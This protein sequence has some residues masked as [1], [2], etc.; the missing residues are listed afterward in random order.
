[1]TSLIQ[2]IKPP[3]ILA[4]SSEIRA[5][6]LRQ[7]GIEFSIC[8]TGINESHLKNALGKQGEKLCISLAIE[9][10]K[11]LNKKAFVLGADQV[12]ICDDKLYEKPKNIVE[13]KEN[14][15]AL[16]GKTHHLFSGLALY[17]SGELL[18]SFSD[19]ASLTMRD[20]SDK[21]LDSY[22]LQYG[23]NVLSSVGG[24]QLESGGVHLFESI[25]GDYFTI[26]GLP[27]LPLLSIL[28]KHN[29]IIT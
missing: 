27:L 4:S 7:A 22:L 13:V 16:K 19:I 10:A 17:N 20:F 8:P 1:M 5:N 26:L 21:F 14:L 12:L 28:R 6:I 15:K 25:K 9:K 11:S 3:L 2:N 29:I 23:H 18:W 24:Y